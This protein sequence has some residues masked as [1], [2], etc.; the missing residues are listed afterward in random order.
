MGQ[1][2]DVFPAVDVCVEARQ[3]SKL[4]ASNSMLADDSITISSFLLELFQCRPTG[5]Y[6]ILVA[7]EQT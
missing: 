1:H 2:F 7:V 5:V 4:F 3:Y 6:R